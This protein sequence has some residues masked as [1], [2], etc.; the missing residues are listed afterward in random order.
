M[1]NYVWTFLFPRFPC[2]PFCPTV[3]S[4]SPFHPPTLVRLFERER[5]RLARRRRRI[6]IRASPRPEHR[7]KRGIMPRYLH[8]KFAPSS[9]HLYSNDYSSSLALEDA[10]LSLSLSW[11]I[12]TL[13]STPR[14]LASSNRAEKQNFTSDLRGKFAI[15]WESERLG[16]IRL[17]FARILCFLSAERIWISFLCKFALGR[18]IK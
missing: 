7:D 1:Q 12:L 13:R 18:K 5:V 17:T 14:P 16:C 10:F 6:S 3:S 4:A 8:I 15:K 9:V 11:R 2:F